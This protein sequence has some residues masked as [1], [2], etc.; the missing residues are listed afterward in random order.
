MIIGTHKDNYNDSRDAHIKADS[1]RAKGY[2]IQGVHYRSM[3][4]AR[5][6]TGISECALSKHTDPNT[7]VFDIDAYRAGCVTSKRWKAVL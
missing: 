1:K 2:I 3:R 6:A 7:R 5:K 4:I